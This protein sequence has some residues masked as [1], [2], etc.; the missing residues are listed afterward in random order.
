MDTYR[1]ARVRRRM[2][3]KRFRGKMSRQSVPQAVKYVPKRVPKLLRVF[4]GS[5]GCVG[6]CDH[7]QTARRYRPR[8]CRELKRFV[9]GRRPKFP[10]A[11]PGAKLWAADLQELQAAREVRAQGPQ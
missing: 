9:T 3:V 2:A 4:R 1:V 7:F 8:A 6:R 11:P 5:S 10:P